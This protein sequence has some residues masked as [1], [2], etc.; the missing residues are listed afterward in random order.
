M[1]HRQIVKQI[2]IQGAVILFGGERSLGLARKSRLGIRKLKYAII[3]C[4]LSWLVR[5]IGAAVQCVW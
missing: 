4:K 2:P 1:D 5:F 3:E